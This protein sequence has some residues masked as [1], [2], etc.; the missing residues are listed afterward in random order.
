MLQYT[1]ESMASV[2]TDY[3]FHMSRHETELWEKS[4]RERATQLRQAMEK[5]VASCEPAL[6]QLRTLLRAHRQFVVMGS[7]HD[8]IRLEME[9]CSQDELPFNG[10]MTFITKQLSLD[11]PH[12]SGP[13]LKANSW[14]EAEKIAALLGLV[15]CGTYGGEPQPELPI[16]PHA[17]QLEG[18]GVPVFEVSGGVLL[19]SRRGS[20]EMNDATE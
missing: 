6:Q 16:S 14:E 15:V 7:L 19:P 20:S 13:D 4:N 17:E 5:L 18:V 12:F 11:M 8:G 9:R 1:A 2:L 10:S 3:T